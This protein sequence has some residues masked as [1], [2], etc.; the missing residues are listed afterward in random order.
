MLE[1][2][3][4]E[5][6]FVSSTLNHILEDL[7]EAEAQGFNLPSPAEVLG[8]E[9]EGDTDAENVIA[10]KH[11]ETIKKLIEDS[12]NLEEVLQQLKKANSTLQNQYKELKDMTNAVKEASA[13]ALH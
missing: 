6:Q 2:K 12:S 3:P 7:Q 9:K 5:Q 13:A 4:S 11:Y 10:T 8:G 1:K